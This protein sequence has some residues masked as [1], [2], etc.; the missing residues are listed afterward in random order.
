MKVCTWAPTVFSGPQVMGQTATGDAPSGAA[1]NSLI[2]DYVRRVEAL[3]V[4]HLLIPQRWWGN[5]KEIEAS[6]LDC[7]AMTSHI[8]AHS[9]RLQLVTA[10]HPG[11]FQPAAIAKWGATLSRLT[12]GRWS[13]NVTSGW[14]LSEFSMYGVDA[15]DHDLRYDRSK[16]FIDVAK[17]AWS[18]PKFSYRGKYYTVRDLVLEPRPVGDLEIF[19][20]GQSAAA[21]E[22]ACEYSDWMFLNG[23]SLEKIRSIIERVRAVAAGG[24]MPKFAVYG[25][26]LC[27]NTDEE[28]VQEIQSMLTAA[29]AELIAARKKRVSGAEGMWASEDELSLLDSNEGFVTGLI[30]SPETILAQIRAF[31]DVGVEMFHLMLGDKLFDEAVLPDMLNL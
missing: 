19:Q 28:A 26:P 4:T 22:M 14:N 3:G 6:S 16:E 27:R 15:L 17:G 25:I 29:D 5:A 7:L 11:F 23:G 10:I 18:D 20:G 9:Q 13:I 8:A 1:L 31:S 12:E 21:I 30:G 24:P 2:K